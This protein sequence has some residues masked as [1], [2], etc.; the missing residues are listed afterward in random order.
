M[1]F[2]EVIGQQKL[3][4]DLIRAVLADKVSHAQLFS[5]QAGYGTLPLALAYAQFLFCEQKQKD[6]SCG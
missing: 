4:S 3:K 2:K 1:R 6:D 5:G